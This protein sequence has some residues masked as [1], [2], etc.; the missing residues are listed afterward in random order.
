[1]ALFYLIDSIVKSCPT[2][3][4]FLEERVLKLFPTTYQSVGNQERLQFKKLLKSWKLN[5]Q[6]YL[7]SA[8]TLRK[9]EEFVNVF[10]LNDFRYI[11]MFILGIYRVNDIG[12]DYRVNTIGI[13][14]RVNDIGIKYINGIGI[15]PPDK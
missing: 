13:D 10:V 6:G 15:N 14:Y 4:P 8:L 5:P 7:F 9:L 12:I 1:M 11:S 2:F 3:L